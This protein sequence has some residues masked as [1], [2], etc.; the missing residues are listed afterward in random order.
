M[1]N[2]VWPC[3]PI[4]NTYELNIKLLKISSLYKMHIFQLM[5]KIFVYTKYL[6]CTSKD[7]IF[8]YL[9]YFK[10][11]KILRSH[12]CFSNAHMCV[13][14]VLSCPCCSNVVV[15]PMPPR[16]V[17]QQ[18]GW[19]PWWSVGHV[20]STSSCKAY[21]IRSRLQSKIHWSAIT[22]IFL[23]EKNVTNEVGE[24]EF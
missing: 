2:I 21:W 17:L 4:N 8:V 12:A 20:T 23:F 19:L 3:V 9:W 22:F 10:S 5:N 24:T 7:I 13:S 16:V 18:R 14:R 6:A 15:M 11:S 1:L